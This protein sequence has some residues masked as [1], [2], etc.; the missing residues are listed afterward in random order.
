[1]DAADRE[2]DQAILSVAQWRW[3]KVA[4]VL[5]ESLVRAGQDLTD[6]NCEKIEARLHA[7]VEAGR[8]Q[9]QGDISNWRQSEV[10]LGLGG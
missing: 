2:L 10:R 4:K 3:Q 6:P 8:L 7:L 9:A 5:V 1:M